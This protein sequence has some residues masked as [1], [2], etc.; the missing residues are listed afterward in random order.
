M[1]R[2]VGFPSR[3]GLVVLFAAL[4]G[5][6]SAT[7]ARRCLVALCVA[8][9]VA[10]LPAL[11]GD[12]VYDDLQMLNNPAS[13]DPSDVLSVFGRN[14]SDY[15]QTSHTRDVSQGATY[16]PL[17]HLTL[18]LVHAAIGPLAWLH[19]LVS[20]AL[21]LTLVGLL[22]LLDRRHNRGST[23]VGLFVCAVLALHPAVG[24]A[25]LWINGRSDL[26]AA[27][28]V[29]LAAWCAASPDRRANWR[30]AAVA[31]A[32]TLAATLSKE[33]ALAAV[34]MVWGVWAV[35]PL[36]ALWR[37]KPTHSG[38]PHTDTSAGIY[39]QCAARVA[40]AVGAAG[41]SLVVY[42]VLLGWTL[43]ADADA[44]PPLDLATLFARLPLLLALGAENLIVPLPRP[45]QLL[46]WSFHEGWTPGRVVLLGAGLAAAAAL[47]ARRQWA[48]LLYA[49]GAV[50]CL[51][52]TGFVASHNWLGFDRYLVLPLLLLA[53]AAIGAV[54]SV[55]AADVAAAD[56]SVPAPVPASGGRDRALLGWAALVFVLSTSLF[57]QARHYRSHQSFVASLVTLAP[58][59][60]VGHVL[61]AQW[62][63]SQGR[64]DMAR[65]YLGAWEASRATQP[66][67]V[68]HAAAGEFL[69]LGDPAAAARMVEAEF[70]KE[71]NNPLVLLDV[72]ALRG[73][74]GRW[75][76]ALQVLARLLASPQTCASARQ[77]AVGWVETPRLSTAVRDALGAQ[78]AA[79]P[80][81]LSP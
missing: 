62:I 79:A 80:C 69:K 7:T 49:L 1:A 71:P 51:L 59:N 39:Q 4:S 76:E 81:Q 56:D 22:F 75:D 55:A 32:T 14:S 72:L 8:T 15:L 46:A 36:L 50:V 10:A 19:H 60:G 18:L 52:P 42:Q 25:W 77:L 38:D 41:L 12:W 5:R 16:R 53:I 40:I 67:A 73:G 17:S 66:V 30:T 21:H 54:P 68:L 58:D 64:P 11:G 65:E 13:D 34:G 9:T 6:P 63:A 20:L 24:E 31:T 44:T 35:S 47:A 27:T 48:V 26:L 57:F 45:M 43:G 70:A 28:I 23:W 78:L 37:K 29:V 33:P 61:Y 2:G 74:Q 3:T